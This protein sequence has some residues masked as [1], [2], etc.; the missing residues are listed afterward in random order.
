MKIEKVFVEKVD[1]DSKFVLKRVVTRNGIF[2]GRQMP[3]TN[4]LFNSERARKSYGLSL[5]RSP[6]QTYHLHKDRSTS[7][8]N[9]DRKFNEARQHARDNN[10]IFLPFQQR[11]V[12]QLT[13]LDWATSEDDLLELLNL[14]LQYV[15]FAVPE[16][17][18]VD[19]CIKELEW[20]KTQ[21]NGSQEI[22]PVLSS[23]HSVVSFRS[24][25][26]KLWGKYKIIGIHFMSPQTN[27]EPGA[28]L[29]DLWD[30]NSQ[31]Q[32]GQE[33]SLIVGFNT[34][35]HYHSSKVAG[36]FVAA[37]HGIDIPSQMQM[38]P[39]NVRGMLSRKEEFPSDDANYIYDRKEGGF[40]KA[41]QQI[42]WYGE[43]VTQR[44][45]SEI[46]LAE[47][48]DQFQAFS[49]NDFMGQQADLYELN[50]AILEKKRVQQ[51]IESKSRWHTYLLES[52]KS[53][54]T[55][56]NEED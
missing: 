22:V 38:P 41:S 24:I 37:R 46:T 48:L 50:M 42:I 9:Y 6:I 29:R 5:L 23:G 13:D 26:S 3:V 56:I 27:P 10:R 18:T 28:N 45:L 49:W 11:T 19:Q 43:N 33:T 20:A 12:Q 21:L 2:L 14:G 39:E 36:S 25:L 32:E 7:A 53:P 8:W 40:N 44:L 52:N 35:K 54:G 30:L 34:R 1:Q 17:A 16:N 47:R 15:P 55:E 31:I 4:S 51:L